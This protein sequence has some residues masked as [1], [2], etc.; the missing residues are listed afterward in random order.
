MKKISADKQK[1]EFINLALNAFSD[2]EALQELMIT[3]K[4]M[5]LLQDK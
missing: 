2:K 5:L 1:L 4:G 3:V